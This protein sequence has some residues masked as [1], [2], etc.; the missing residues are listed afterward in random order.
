[1]TLL[2][3]N[4]KSKREIFLINLSRKAQPKIMKDQVFQDL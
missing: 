2:E 1:V 3:L 4:S